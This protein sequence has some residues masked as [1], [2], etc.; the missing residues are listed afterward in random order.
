ML[1]CPLTMI[2]KKG[3]SNKV[4]EK[5][6]T[7][8]HVPLHNSSLFSSEEMIQIFSFFS[9]KASVLVTQQAGGPCICTWGGCREEDPTI[10]V[11]GEA[12]I[13]GFRV[14]GLVLAAADAHSAGRPRLLP[15]PAL[16]LCWGE[17]REGGR[18]E[19]V[20]VRGGVGWLLSMFSVDSH[21]LNPRGAPGWLSH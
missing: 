20:L 18:R 15:A 3:G 9:L 11:G 8:F 7:W 14:F 4:N 19:T 21:G 12:L 6:N 16:R 17:G 13:S 1:S 5:W 10:T 2:S